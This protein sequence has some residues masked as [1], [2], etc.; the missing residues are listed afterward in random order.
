MTFD[1]R[2]GSKP[3]D[4][5]TLTFGAI[6]ILVVA[7]AFFAV[8]NL[9]KKSASDG[10]FPI[11]SAQVN[12]VQH[13][14]LEGK[15]AKAFLSALGRIDPNARADLD[16]RL[17]KSD[18]HD[19][20]RIALAAAG[21]VLS[22]HQTTLANANTRHVDDWLDM[23]RKELRSASRRNHRW[24][25]GIRY[26]NF[27]A[28]SGLSS[29]MAAA[30]DLADLGSELTDYSF[31]S[32]SIA[33][34][35]IE[36]ARTSPVNHG[37]LTHQDES[38]LQGVAMSIISDPQIMPLMLAANSGGPSPTMLE[39][40]DMCDLGVTAVTAL[41]TLPQ[42]TK[43]RAFSEFVMSADFGSG[44]LSQLGKLSRL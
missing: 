31:A 26:Q 14:G 30:S 24:C 32:I 36:D 6:T 1:A 40:L 21:K 22:Q 8:L 17:S 16:R 39:S 34:A 23:T 28:A 25:S 35:A 38:A 19:H 2:G 20:A 33:F 44:D 15:S 27:D 13:A 18:Q 41:K 42:G 37:K 7:G 29:Q 43:G 3:K 4:G 12:S 5:N 9:P 10:P 11:A